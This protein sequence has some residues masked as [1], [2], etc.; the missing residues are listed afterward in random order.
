MSRHITAIFILAIGSIV[1]GY[2]AI[3]VAF[4]WHASISE[5]FTGDLHTQ[6]LVTLLAAWTVGLL[7]GH[8]WFSVDYSQKD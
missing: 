8:W 3:A 4:G 1:L 7:C 6:S 2:D 5:C